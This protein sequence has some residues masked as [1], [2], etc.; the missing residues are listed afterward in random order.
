MDIVKLG[1][2]VMNAGPKNYIICA[3]VIEKTK[4]IKNFAKSQ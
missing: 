4:H 3:L 2:V 1:H